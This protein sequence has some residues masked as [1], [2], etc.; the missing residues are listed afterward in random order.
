MSM[1]Y[2][3]ELQTIRGYLIVEFLSVTETWFQWQR[4]LH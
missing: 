2:N 3:I 1:P 4:S